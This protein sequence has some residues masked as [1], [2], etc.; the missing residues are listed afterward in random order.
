MHADD[1]LLRITAGYLHLGRGLSKGVCTSRVEIQ[2]EKQV[3]LQRV[4]RARGSSAIFS[5]RV[6]II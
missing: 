2:R 3:P 6:C 5:R 1:I 4:E